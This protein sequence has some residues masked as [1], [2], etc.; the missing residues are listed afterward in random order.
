MW[1][2]SPRQTGREVKEGKET[3]GTAKRLAEGEFDLT[4]LSKPKR[5][6]VATLTCEPCQFTRNDLH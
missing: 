1:R 6:N 4:T 3:L 5:L 2:E